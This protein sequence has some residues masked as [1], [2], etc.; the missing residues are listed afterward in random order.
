M[1]K[2]FLTY[3]FAAVSLSVS[4]QV[5]TQ[6]FESGSRH[7]EELN[8]WQF[9]GTQIN[10]GGNSINDQWACRSQQ[11]NDM[12]SVATPHQLISPWVDMTSGNL[13]FLSRL[14]ALNGGG[15]YMDVYL[16]DENGGST[17]ILQH[18][19]TTASTQ[20][21]SIPVSVTGLH[22]VRWDFYGSGGNTRG[23][24]DDI[25]IPGTY[26]SDPTNNPGQ[27]GNC[28]AVQPVVDSDNDGVEDDIDEYPN[29]A[30]KAY[31]NYYPGEGNFGT[32]AYE[33]LWPS[34]GDYDFND[35]VVDYS[36]NEISNANNQIV[37]IEA[38][39]YV[40]A[41]GGSYDNGFAIAFD[42]LTSSNIQA[43]NGQVL[44]GNLFATN[45]N[46]TEGG[47]NIAVVPVF[48]SAENVINRVGGSMYNTIPLNGTGVSDTVYL[49][50]ELTSPVNTVGLAPYNPFLVKNQ[51]RGNEIHLP[52]MA[53][54]DLV[55]NSVFG[56]QDDATNPS[57]SKYYKTANNLPWAIDVPASFEYPI[58]GAD[59]IDAY[60]KFADWAQSSG[61]LYN[62]WY[63]NNSPTYRDNSKIY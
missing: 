59:I 51:V 41:V 53:P 12:P 30:S 3:V 21:F 38:V 32:L 15:K 48:N 63:N 8:C 36:F 23:I 24:V 17:L 43:V 26:A 19:Y 50:I 20:S 31:N 37:E 42:E 10:G 40:R 13:T 44:S 46:G 14:T 7:A 22:Q 16:L 52:D 6:D 39:L 54:T 55:D 61:A 4:A 18:T 25:S 49:T 60:L 58:E 33:D 45:S 62:D 2:S 9:Y 27:I 29:D 47:Q 1:R 57:S 5:V 34:Q 11:M 56:T 35:L 28:A